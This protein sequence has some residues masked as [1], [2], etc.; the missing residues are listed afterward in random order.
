MFPSIFRTLAKKGPISPS[1]ER[2]WKLDI[3]FSKNF[4]SVPNIILVY[5]WLVVPEELSNNTY[6]LVFVNYINAESNALQM[7]NRLL[8]KHTSIP[9][10]GARSTGPFESDGVARRET[11]GGLLRTCR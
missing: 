7:L 4:A 8:S 11:G 5:S 6:I 10:V 2:F 1:E 3:E 9:T